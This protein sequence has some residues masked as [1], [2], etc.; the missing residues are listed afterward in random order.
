MEICHH[1]IPIETAALS[2]PHTSPDWRELQ[3]DGVGLVPMGTSKRTSDGD[4][5]WPVSGSQTWPVSG[6]WWTSRT[7]PHDME[8]SGGVDPWSQYVSL[9]GKSW[10]SQ[11]SEMNSGWL[12]VLNQSEIHKSEI[13]QSVS[14]DIPCKSVSLN[15]QWK[16]RKLYVLLL[17][18]RF[19][20][21]LETSLAPKTD[22]ST[23][24]ECSPSYLGAHP[25]YRKWKW[26]ITALYISSI[27]TYVK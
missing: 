5:T 19:T 1:T 17:T 13:V 7:L 20:S 14:E 15:Q 4:H 11:T 2:A 6:C 26:V 12:W 18:L 8:A 25:S 23:T 3:W 9:L 22:G 10:Q 16:H 24:G 27:Y 21:R